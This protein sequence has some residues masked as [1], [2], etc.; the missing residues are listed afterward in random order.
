MISHKDYIDAAQTLMANCTGPDMATLELTSTINGN[1]ET[2]DFLRAIRELDGKLPDFKTS[3]RKIVIHHTHLISN[4]CEYLQ[5]GDIVFFDDCLYSQYVFLKDNINWL[6]NHRIICILGFSAM[7]FRAAEKPIY[8][9]KSAELHDRIHNGD[10]SALAGF[11]SIAEIQELLTFSNIYL[12]CHG[13]WHLD[14]QHMN[15]S[16]IDMF[17]AFNNDVVQAKKLFAI[18][19]FITDIFVYPYAYDFF[20]SDKILHNNGFKQIYAGKNSKRIE[21]E[22]L[23]SK[24]QNL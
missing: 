15:L 6:I 14:L 10:K 18:Y 23:I 2:A 3:N 1:F 9:I 13:S 24:K 16:K 17:K 22:E 8:G 19:G 5:D 21:I 12:A 20:I 4:I 11:M 7:L